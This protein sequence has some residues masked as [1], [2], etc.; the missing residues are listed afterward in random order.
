[1]ALNALDYI[2]TSS[3]NSWNSLKD[4]I[5]KNHNIT[6]DPSND[7]D[8]VVIAYLRDKIIHNDFIESENLTDKSWETFQR[9]IRNYRNNITMS[10]D[11]KNLYLL[12]RMLNIDTLDEMKVFKRLILHEQEFSA[13]NLYDF[14]TMCCLKLHLNSIE[15]QA[16]IN[17]YNTKIRC[18]ELAPTI[19]KDGTT[20]TLESKIDKISSFNDIPM[21]IAENSEVFSLTRNTTYLMLYQFVDWR[22]W[23]SQ[24]WKEFYDRNPNVA[25]DDY[26]YFTDSDWEDHD[27]NENGVS[28]EQMQE[29]IMYR[30]LDELYDRNLDYKGTAYSHYI[31][32]TVK[33]FR[34]D[35]VYA[36]QLYD[37]EKYK[38]YNKPNDILVSPT[39]KKE[40]YLKDSYLELFS[41]C[42][43][44]GISE[45]QIYALAS[46]DEFSVAFLTFEEYCNLFKR[47]TSYEIK[48]G[49]YLLSLL[50]NYYFDKDEDRPLFK[51]FD[52]K[53]DFVEA[54]E[55]ILALGGFPS[56]NPNN[57]FDHL[58]IDTYTEIANEN[59]SHDDIQ[60][61]FLCRLCNYL[62]EIADIIISHSHTV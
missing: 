39:S 11:R 8:K 9:N 7:S 60:D 6:I 43:E 2:N 29:L 59:H 13:R 25:P 12:M 31:K 16:L 20:G 55:D 22:A 44:N 30:Y 21:L 4:Y 28:N 56:L 33:N 58:F 49:V 47:K 53:V 19:V 41:I 32:D 61:E 42:R 36:R 37:S 48:H 38:K 45:D 5:I 18:M 34:N 46:H 35:F 26:K 57:G 54:I 23:D 50:E 52:D 40:N 15:H 17:T 24:E 27:P 51:I 1:M 10:F 14:I 62:K 3:H